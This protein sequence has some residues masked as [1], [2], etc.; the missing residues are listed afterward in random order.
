MISQLAL[1]TIHKHQLTSILSF[2]L[3]KKLPP[4]CRIVNSTQQRLSLIHN[5]LLP[6]LL[7][8]AVHQS[9]PLKTVLL[10]NLFK[11]T[12]QPSHNI[13]HIML[14]DRITVNITIV[15][16][17]YQ[18][19]RAQLNSKNNVTVIIIIMLQCMF[20]IHC[21]ISV[22]KITQGTGT[23]QDCMHIDTLYFQTKS[24]TRRE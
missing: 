4:N 23:S 22:S 11:L 9:P 2:N 7:E 20:T 21:Q 15:L 14:Q 10:F 17:L 3:E 5:L 19:S 12:T 18:A 8:L 6:Q 24:S 1:L 13:M 16:V